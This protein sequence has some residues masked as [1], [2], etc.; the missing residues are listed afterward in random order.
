MT[1]PKEAQSRRNSDGRGLVSLSKGTWPLCRWLRSRARLVHLKEDA[2]MAA[3]H[4]R[5]QLLALGREAN[6]LPRRTLPP[7]SSPGP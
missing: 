2:Q 1:G 4:S 6:R 7:R 5:S 3:G